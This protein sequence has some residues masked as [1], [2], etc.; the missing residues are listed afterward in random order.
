MSS[1]CS[2]SLNSPIRRRETSSFSCVTYPDGLVWLLAATT[3][4]I[5]W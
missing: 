2:T 1:S 4:Q 5:L 3:E